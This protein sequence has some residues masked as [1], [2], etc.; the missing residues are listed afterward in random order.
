MEQNKNLEGQILKLCRKHLRIKQKDLGTML[1]YSKATADVRIAQY[2]GGK[3][4]PNSKAILRICEILGISEYAI[5]PPSFENELSVIHIMMRIDT[6]YGFEMK[7]ENGE[8]YLSF[9]KDCKALRHY[10]H[11]LYRLKELLDKEQITYETYQYIKAAF[12]RNHENAT[13]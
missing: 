4:K 2:E 1:G 8:I 9:P 13:K 3:R 5:R 7:E 10:M 6:L 11:Q 12:G